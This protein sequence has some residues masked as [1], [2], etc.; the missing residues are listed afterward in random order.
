[1]RRQP[2]FTL[3]EIMVTI[4]IIAI[5][6]AVA[7]P[8]YTDYVRRGKIQE[9]TSQLLAMRT[10]MEQYYQDNRSY[11]TPGAPVIDACKAGSSVPK[12]TLKY[13][14]ID[15]DT[16]ARTATTYTI[17]AV[18]GS[19]E[20]Q[21][22]T[23]ISFTIDQS[24]TRATTVTGGSIMAKAGYQSNANCWTVKKGGQC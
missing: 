20:D 24:N 19:P 2:G 21:S 8:N 12:P 10:K 7:I 18:G 22:M 13:F 14:V 3:I 1:M 5:L 9:A 11:I 23:G 16:P 17:T 4:A 15:C 6:A